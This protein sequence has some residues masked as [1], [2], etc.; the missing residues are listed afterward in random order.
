MVYLKVSNPLTLSAGTGV[1]LSN[2]GVGF[3]GSQ[4]LTQTISIGQPVGTT[5][6]VTFNQV[7]TNSCI[8]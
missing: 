2:D 7:S 5:D 1:T 8:W 3:D 6:N 4:P